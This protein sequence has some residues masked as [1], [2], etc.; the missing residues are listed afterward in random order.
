MAFFDKF[1]SSDDLS[2][3]KTNRDKPGTTKRKTPMRRLTILVEEEKKESGGKEKSFSE[4][5]K[6]GKRTSGVSRDTVSRLKIL[7][8]KIRHRVHYIDKNDFA[9][10]AVSSKDKVYDFD[11]RRDLAYFLA[12][13]RLFAEDN[14]EIDE[15]ENAQYFQKFEMLLADAASD[16][17]I[18]YVVYGE[19]TYVT[20]KD[21]Y[22]GT[23]ESK[24]SE[25]IKQT[26]TTQKSEKNKK[27]IR[28]NVSESGVVKF[29]EELIA[30]FKKKA[31]LFAKNLKEESRQ[32]VGDMVTQEEYEILTK[33]FTK[34][35]LREMV[36]EK[37]RIEKKKLFSNK[38]KREEFVRLI[39]DY[40]FK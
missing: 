27:L 6:H 40:I 19:Q 32:E 22:S 28:E 7:A 14:F 15:K 5:V 36:A 18:S 39:S 29:P 35:F 4:E 16:E 13:E 23:Q 33:I 25:V 8:E 26:E 11:L 30:I 2:G 21:E 31:A 9:K 37:E 1:F 20:G 17:R 3:A 24:P 34:R 12:N 10:K 38:H